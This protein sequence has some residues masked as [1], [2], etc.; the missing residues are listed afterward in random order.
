MSRVPCMAIS[1]LFTDH[2]LTGTSDL[3]NGAIMPWTSCR[4]HES[5]SSTPSPSIP[6]PLTP[7][8]L[9][10]CQQDLPFKYDIFRFNLD[11]TWDS[12]FRRKTLRLCSFLDVY[13]LS[14]LIHSPAS[15]YLPSDSISLLLM[16]LSHATIPFCP[17]YPSSSTFLP[18]LRKLLQT[19]IFS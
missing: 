2:F 13:W 3:E 1:I 5:C 6:P 11:A 7:L 9:Q 12:P 18:F 4:W 16:S 17:L 15:C 10:I 8:P 19:S 14:L